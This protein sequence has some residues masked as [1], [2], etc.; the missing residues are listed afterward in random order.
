[1]YD[2]PTF[3]HAPS[4]GAT[5]EP[6]LP[7]S[8]SPGTESGRL[9]DL[10]A[11][12]EDFEKSY[13]QPNTELIQAKIETERLRVELAAAEARLAEIEEKVIRSRG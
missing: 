12:A 2:H 7:T 8:S 9:N 3:H 6:G 13:G 10:D 11:A 1:V 5:I 4:I